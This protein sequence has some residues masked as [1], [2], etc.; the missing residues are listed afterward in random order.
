[1]L[2]LYVWYVSCRCNDDYTN[3]E[4][5]LSRFELDLEAAVDRNFDFASGKSQGGNN[6]EPNRTTHGSTQ[7]RGRQA[8]SCVISVVTEIE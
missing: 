6:T 8:G 5:H 2:S 1:M 7:V 3:I 4:H